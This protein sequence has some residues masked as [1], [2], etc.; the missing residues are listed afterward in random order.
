MPADGYQPV[1][2]SRRVDAHADVVFGVLADPG[3]HTSLDGTGML[4]GAV[5]TEPVQ[6]VGDVFVMRMYFVEL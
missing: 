2:V 4:R 3:T 1:T 6:G 5:S